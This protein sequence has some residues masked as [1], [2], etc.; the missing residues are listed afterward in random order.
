MIVAADMIGAERQ[1]VINTV[2]CLNLSENREI[3][4]WWSGKVCIKLY[5]ADKYGFRR[6]KKKERVSEILT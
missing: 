3:G 2:M 1:T 6:P 4:N 5:S